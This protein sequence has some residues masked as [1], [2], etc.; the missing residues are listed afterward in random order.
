[1][2]ALLKALQDSPPPTR[3][4]PVRAL[5]YYGPEA[6]AAVPA[7]LPLLN[8]PDLGTRVSATNSL[9]L[10]APEALHI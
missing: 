8:D 2:P 4:F 1:V 6:K 3:A 5:G 7:I 9:K 10:I